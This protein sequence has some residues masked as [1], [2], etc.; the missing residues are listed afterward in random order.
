MKILRALKDRRKINQCK[1][2]LRDVLKLWPKPNEDPERVRDF[3]VQIKPYITSDFDG[4]HLLNR[5]SRIMDFGDAYVVGPSVFIE[6]R[7]PEDQGYRQRAEFV[8]QPDG[9]WLVRTIRFECPIC[10][11][12]GKIYNGTICELCGGQGWGVA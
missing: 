2:L 4:S 8:E 9:Q 10:F 12:E 5:L 1:A 6:F 7:V 11:R 3:L